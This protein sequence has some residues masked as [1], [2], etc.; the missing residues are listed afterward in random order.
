MNVC[1]IIYLLLLNILS[2]FYKVFIPIF[3][4]VP[5]HEI[6]YIAFYSARGSIRSNSKS[7]VHEI[8]GSLPLYHTMGGAMAM[9][10]DSQC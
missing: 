3:F 2:V 10:A 8:P 1:I 6:R 9:A 4:R 7:C 5:T